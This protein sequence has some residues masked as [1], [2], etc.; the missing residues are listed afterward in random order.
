LPEWGYVLQAPRRPPLKTQLATMRANGLDAGPLGP[1]W[2]DSIGRSKAGPR[3]G[4]LQ[5]PERNGL[6]LAVQPG[7]RVFVA[8]AYCLGVSDR[9]AAWFIGELSTRGASLTVSGPTYHVE[10]GGDASELIKAV[11]RKQNT[12]NVA[13]YRKRKRKS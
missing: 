6:L 11:A 13:A 10:P 3:S 5:L 9:D 7:D 8:D 2:S 4:E 12:A 1:I